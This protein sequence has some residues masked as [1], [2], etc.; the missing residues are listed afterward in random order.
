MLRLAKVSEATRGQTLDHQNHDTY[1]KYQSTLKSLDVQ[2]LFYDLEPDYECRDMEQSMA[3]H[4]DP[5]T[6]RH[7]NAAGLAAFERDEEIIALNQ[8][9]AKLTKQIRGQPDSHKD[10]V[11]VRTSLYSKKAKKL[12]AK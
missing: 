5:N 3:H 2:A 10:L 6:P 4:Q 12:E 1:L 9:I 7:L 11:K 8:E